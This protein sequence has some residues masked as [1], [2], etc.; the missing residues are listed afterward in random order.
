MVNK[1]KVYEML[2]IF[3]ILLV[4]SNDY[5]MAAIALAIKFT[6][7]WARSRGKKEEMILPKSGS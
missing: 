5:S 7:Q 3:L 6:F 1:D 2:Q 4:I